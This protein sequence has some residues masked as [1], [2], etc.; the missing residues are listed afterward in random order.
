M[1]WTSTTDGSKQWEGGL[2]G[3]TS[4]SVVGASGEGLPR[5]VGLLENGTKGTKARN[6]QRLP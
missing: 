1:T 2:T 4:G 5:A 6:R 3:A